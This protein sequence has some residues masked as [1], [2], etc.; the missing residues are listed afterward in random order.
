MRCLPASV[1]GLPLAGLL[2][3]GG[4]GGCG[5]SSQGN[6]VAA[7]TPAEIVAGAKV[8]AEAA[9]AVHVSGSIVSNGT[10]ITLNLYLVAS[11]G[12]RGEVAVNGLSFEVI[13][14]HGTVFVKGSPA[15]YRHVAG[16][17]AAQLLQGRWLKAPASS[18]SF[19]ALS[20]LTEVRALA[21]ATLAPH[22]PLAK[23]AT[24]T[25]EGR[26]AVAVRDTSTGGTL[27]V[28]TSGPPYPLAITA[29][30]AGAGKVVFDHW[31]AVVPVLPPSSTLDITQFQSGH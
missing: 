18:G 24:T 20:P 28:A 16:P 4:L 14:I 7:R 9:S 5:G 27:F 25:V 29:A 2:A 13:R 8:L 21:D 6:G 26:R 1:A 30:G 17:A 12:G 22:G 19:A 10:P 11:R 23:G 31:N 15:F 3:I